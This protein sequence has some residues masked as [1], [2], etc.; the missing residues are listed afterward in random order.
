M[1]DRVRGYASYAAWSAYLSGK[2]LLVTRVKY[3]RAFRVCLA[4]LEESQ[5]WSATELRDLQ[6]QKLR[7]LIVHAYEN[8]PYYRTLFQKHGLTP[9]DIRSVADLKKIPILT[10]ADLRDHA[11]EL[12]ARNFHPR[13]LFPG[14]T[15]GSTGT[16]I[17][18]LRTRQSIVAENAMIWRQRHWAG[19]RTG[20]RKAAVWGAIW[21]DTIVPASQDHPPPFWRWNLADHQLLFSYY[22]MSEE[23]LPGYC[24][25]LQAA[26]IEFIEGFPST[27]LIVAQHLQRHDRFVPLKAVFTSSEPLYPE[28]R[29]I[30]EERFRTKVFDLYGQAERVVAATE[31]ELH[32]G[33]HDNPEY[34]V[35]EILKGDQDAGEGETGVIVGTSLTKFGMPLIR[36]AT[37]DLGRKGRGTC[38]CGRQTQLLTGIEGRLSDLIRTPEGMTIPGNGIMGALHGVTNVRRTQVIQEELDRLSVLLVKEDPAREVDTESLRKSIRG[39]VGRSMRIDLRFVDEKSCTQDQVPLGDLQAP[40]APDLRTWVT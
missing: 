30:I 40:A 28:H 13:L 26:R 16:P 39:C 29:A 23:T 5:W 21:N 15:T 7:S 38:P 14:W 24:D 31:C 4:E 32:Q 19:V 37:G 33:L 12:V 34:G 3:S 20:A 22:H 25:K 27:L 10:K 9:A 8:V 1:L 6:E 2:G 18:A 36:Y 17:N 11:S 35:L